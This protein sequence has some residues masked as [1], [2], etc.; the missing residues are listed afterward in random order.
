MNLPESFVNRMKDMLG[1]EAEAFLASL[2]GTHY[3]GLRINERKKPYGD[4]KAFDSVTK[5]WGLRQVPWCQSGF[6]YAEEARPGKHP[7]HA[8]GVYYIQEPSAMA[9]AEIA[10]IEPGERVLD[11]CAAPGGKTT[12]LADALQGKGLLW[13]NEIVSSRASILSENVERLGI[14]NAVVSCM[15]PDSLADR[16]PAFFT[17]IVVDTPCSGEGMFRRDEIARK[18]WSED[19]VT[20]CAKRGQSILDAADKMLTYGG[21]LVYSTCTF[22]PVE[23][24]EAVVRFIKSHPEYKIEKVDITPISGASPDDGFLSCGEPGWCEYANYNIAGIENTFRLWPHRLSGEGHYVAVLRKGERTDRSELVKGTT[25]PQRSVK[26]NGKALGE[27]VREFDHFCKENGISIDDIVSTEDERGYELFGDNLYLR[28]AGAPASAGF[29]VLRM[30]LQLGELKK[31]RFE[32]S[33][34]LAMALLERDARQV[35]RLP[36]ADEDDRIYRYLRGESISCDSGLKGWC[37]VTVDGYSCGWGKASNGQ[38]KN[39]YPKG[40]RVQG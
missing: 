24:E 2:H 1:D 36:L 29:K 21:K 25:S 7:Y 15:D 10:R 20:M 26:G 6:Y 14:H 34:A 33:H 23:D 22:A 4:C 31:N 19:N 27:A 40:L 13:S 8:A 35:V 9:V 11:L 39:H 3:R 5:D 17:T 37:V 18:E 38:L 16:L 28:P 30:G 12:Q 32:P